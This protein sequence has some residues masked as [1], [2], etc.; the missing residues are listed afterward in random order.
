MTDLTTQQFLTCRYSAHEVLDEKL[1][2]LPTADELKGACRILLGSFPTRKVQDPEVYVRQVTALLADYPAFVVRQIIDPKAGIVSRQ[3][4]LPTLA[5]LRDFAEGLVSGPRRDRERE[6]SI[7]RQIE[8]RDEPAE[9]K[10]T[11]AELKE[12]Y[13]NDWGIHRDADEAVQKHQRWRADMA[14][15]NE[16]LRADEL[17]RAGIDPASTPHSLAF[18]KS[19]GALPAQAE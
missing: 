17:R 15:T 3:K 18:L 10:P 7:I 6:A 8:R 11:M 2:T 14:E 5:E 9:P 19:I 1:N 4:F 12:T 16:R 13:G